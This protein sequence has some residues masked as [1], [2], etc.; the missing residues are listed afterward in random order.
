MTK[1]TTVSAF[2]VIET[3]GK[4]YKVAAGDTISI[5]KL[6]DETKVGDSV[7]FENILLVDDGSKT[8]LGAPFI[9]GHKVTAK[10]VDLGLGDKVTVVKYRQKSRYYKKR[11]HRQPFV[12]VQIESIK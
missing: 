3:G 5:E 6:S 8:T 12:S 2:A 4:Q 10:V 9:K 11:G 7:T 1:E